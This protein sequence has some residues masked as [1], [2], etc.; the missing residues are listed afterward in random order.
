MLHIYKNE[1]IDRQDY[2]W[3]QVQSLFSF[4]N[5]LDQDNIYFGIMPTLNEYHV[6]SGCGF[7]M[8]PHQD[9]ELLY[10]IFDGTLEH[11]DTLGNECI[12]KAGD[13]QRISA[14][15][16][17]ARSSYNSSPEKLHYLTIWLMPK[18]RGLAPSHEFKH[19]P[20]ELYRNCLF[21]IV[22]DRIQPFVD[23]NSPVS[24][25]ASATVYRASFARD[26]KGEE[27]VPKG[28]YQVLY[29]LNGSLML[30]DVLLGKGDHARVELEKSLK[31][32]P[33]D[34]VELFL[35]DMY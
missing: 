23:E 9:M 30:N 18:A 20:L 26:H 32:K 29:V 1:D 28:T 21:P 19:F 4:A 35:I 31:I 22:S 3:L 13:V 2:E 7:P 11:K 16:G 34:D 10:F 17:I 27:F 15:K 14:G 8:H 5:Y 25:N 24:V 6:T 33:N 12:L